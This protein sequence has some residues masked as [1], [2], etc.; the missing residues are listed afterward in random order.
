MGPKRRGR[1]SVG[2]GDRE[3]RVK[4]RK[5]SKA[6][7]SGGAA[8]S[9]FAR[10][11]QAK[12]SSSGAA[13]EVSDCEQRFSCATG[14]SSPLCGS[15]EIEPEGYIDRCDSPEMGTRS[16]HATPIKASAVDASQWSQSAS[17]GCGVVLHAATAVES[18]PQ[19]VSIVR[20]Q[21]APVAVSFKPLEA[22]DPTKVEVWANSVRQ[23]GE[24]GQLAQ[25]SKEQLYVRHLWLNINVR[26]CVAGHSAQEVEKWTL[27][28][29][30]RA[31]RGLIESVFDSAHVSGVPFAQTVQAFVD[32]LNLS[33]IDTI[34]IEAPIQALLVEVTKFWEGDLVLDKEHEDESYFCKL[35]IEKLLR[36]MIPSEG[37]EYL[38]GVWPELMKNDLERVYKANPKASWS[39]MSDMLPW[40][41]KWIQE[42]RKHYV[43]IEQELRYVALRGI[44]LPGVHLGKGAMRKGQSGTPSAA[45]TSSRYQKVPSPFNGKKGVAVSKV[46]T[47][48]AANSEHCTGCGRHGHIAK[49]C[50]LKSHPDYNSDEK[51]EWKNSAK[52]KLW[53]AR[54]PGC[55]V[56]PFKETLEA[57]ST[58]K[59]PTIP[60]KKTTGEQLY[61]SGCTARRGPYTGRVIHRDDTGTITVP[62]P[63][64]VVAVEQLDGVQPDNRLPVTLCIPSTSTCTSSI[65]SLSNVP[66][67][68]LDTGSQAGRS[69]KGHYIA[70]RLAD[71]LQAAHAVPLDRTERMRVCSCLGVCS[72]VH[73]SVRL[74]IVLNNRVSN[75]IFVFTSNF[76][77][78]DIPEGGPDLIVGA[79]ALCTHS[80]LAR[81]LVQQILGWQLS[82]LTYVRNDVLNTPVGR[83]ADGGVQTTQSDG[84]VVSNSPVTFSDVGVMKDARSQVG[85]L[86][87]RHEESMGGDANQQAV[88]LG[89]FHELPE[90]IE[91]SAELQKL[92]LDVCT[93]FRHV[94]SR[95]LKKQPAKVVPMSMSIDVAKW[96]RPENCTPC[97]LQST[98]RN[99]EISR[100]VQEML[101]AGIIRP[102]TATHYSHVLLVP[103]AKQ[104]GWRFCIDYRRLNETTKAP[105]WPLPVIKDMLNRLGERRPQFFAVLDLTKGYY[106]APLEEGSKAFTAFRTRDGIYEWNRVPMGLCGAPAYFQKEMVLT[107]LKPLLQ[108]A[109]E[110]YMD[111]IIIIGNTM[112]QYIENLEAV[113]AKLAEHGLTV[114]P[115][116]CKLGVK[117]VEYVGHLIDHEGLHFT[118]EKLAKVIRWPKPVLAKEL[119]SF[120]GLANFFR[121]HVR[122]HSSIVHPLNEMLHNYRRNVKL[123]WGAK[124]DAAFEA[125]IQAINTCP[126]L[127]FLDPDLPI[128]LYTDASNV[129][130]GAYLC[131]KRPDGSDYPVAMFSKTFNAVQR[132]W[133]TPEQE[134]Y[135]IVEAFKQFSYLLRDTPF[136]L[137]TDHANL[138]Y[139]R[140]SGSSKVIRWKL[141]MQEYMFTL[142]HLPGKENIAADAL[143]RN[144]LAEEDAFIP[145]HSTQISQ[146]LSFLDIGESE[147]T[148]PVDVQQEE[149]LC[150][151]VSW[152]TGTIPDDKYELIKQCHNCVV[153]H[154]GREATIKKILAKCG[155]PWPYM[156]N[157]VRRFIR[158]CDTCQKM[159]TIDKPVIIQSYTTGG[160][161]PMERLNIDSIGPFTQ[162]DENGNKYAVVMIDC[163][164]RFVAVYP[165]LDSSA[166]AAATALLNHC[167][168]FGTPCQIC[169]DRGSQYVNAVIAEFLELLGAEQITTVAYSKQE[170]SMVERANR[171]INRWLRDLIYD[172]GMLSRNWYKAIPYAVRLH[173]A[174]VIETIGTS[175]AKLVFGERLDLDKNILLPADETVRSVTDAASQPLSEWVETQQMMQD[176]VVKRAQQM[177]VKHA[178]KHSS[179]AEDESG[180]I[181]VPTD[182]PIG[183]Y[184]LMDYPA[185]SIG[186]ERPHKLL[187]VRR[188]PYKV[189]A[190]EGNTYRLMNLVTNKEEQ[191]KQIH[192]LRPYFYDERHV[193]PVKMALKDYPDRYEVESISA[194]KG[195]FYR[196]SQLKLLVHW[197]GY[198]EPTWEPWANVRLTQA[199]IA[200]LQSIGESKHIP[201][202]VQN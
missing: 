168:Y 89:S 172:K 163:F 109:C 55:T 90:L 200:Y 133:S 74:S 175:P 121:D 102:S 179:A 194:H 159:C 183:S 76:V 186:E 10:I 38:Y 151:A 126:K 1:D 88:V 15:T 52:G 49:T 161:H 69:L 14:T 34:L 81:L 148:L 195:S 77:V 103:K 176:A 146:Y 166:T 122:N 178:M 37:H 171:E 4:R 190:R 155:A 99:I 63:E 158:E 136:E 170:N 95:E 189:L 2:K 111:D 196:K 199:L 13:E 29:L 58:Y 144:M 43:V 110:V 22:L 21:Q 143:S 197:V 150:M 114:N 145:D 193:D 31:T 153:G 41:T 132:R 142:H 30:V 44:Q 84:N 96:H 157:H 67:C 134:C 113:L 79:S 47:P 17:P 8:A 128:H 198:K 3:H 59:K 138:L 164:T 202:T 187:A 160:Y 116:K 23:L 66:L 24:T 11:L 174:S 12:Y 180:E 60:R 18:L 129:G 6:D 104:G 169:S 72:S 107:V 7:A 70:R 40:I 149:L 117:S 54:R 147:E 152:E 53:A 36:R 20:V 123:K 19:A 124:E 16:V 167:A 9:P 97:R 93:K 92:Q 188:G 185:H 27:D 140:D 50:L 139:I 33:T 127:F 173:N 119:K 73:E 85:Q 25:M 115:D 181:P 80:Q 131:Q 64:I 78:L 100:Q 5:S 154:H 35:L 165:T 108:I 65:L 82:Q 26:W 201:K 87:A 184:V 137:Y 156:R 105:K 86:W 106:Q 162:P 98:Q 68:L 57:N 135:A 192:L 62:S 46:S 101:R 182:F 39:W 71:D 51:I 28:Q 112:E 94:F 48:V 130:M 141:E 191:P 177:A 56:L 45:G 120:L 83:D 91:G 118:P 75:E 61:C 42:F 32:S 125:I